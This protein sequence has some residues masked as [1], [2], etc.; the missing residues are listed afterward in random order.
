MK[1]NYVDGEPI[2]RLSAYI[3]SQKG[4][5]KVPNDQDLGKFMIYMSLLSKEA[6]F[7]GTILAH[8]LVLKMKGWYLSNHKKF[9]HFTTNKYMTK[10]YY[11]EAVFTKMEPMKWIKA[12]EQAG[13]LHMLCVP[14]FNRSITNTICVRQFLMLVHD[15]C[16]WLGKPIPKT[17]MLIHIIKK[18]PYKGWIQPRSLEKKVRIRNM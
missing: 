2:N 11:E 10:I 3:P 6:V 1:K 7:E 5:V 14:N 13:L 16:L 4:K 8:I 15:E 12:V 9:L 18:F 17:N